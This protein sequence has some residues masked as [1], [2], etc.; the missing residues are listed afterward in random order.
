MARFKR[1]FSWTIFLFFIFLF[2]DFFF[3]GMFFKIRFGAVYKEKNEI[4]WIILLDKYTSN[5]IFGFK[6]FKSIFNLFNGVS[7]I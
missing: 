6:K 1:F 3:F 2:V 7:K 5:N 4:K